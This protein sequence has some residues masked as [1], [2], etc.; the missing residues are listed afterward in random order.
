LLPSNQ[1]H[2]TTH[3]TKSPSSTTKSSNHEKRKKVTA[4]HYTTFQFLEKIF[5]KLKKKGNFKETQSKQYDISITEGNPKNEW[6]ATYKLHNP[7]ELKFK[8]L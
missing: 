1:T 3:S 4:V 7:E 8:K 2:N 5:N 6:T